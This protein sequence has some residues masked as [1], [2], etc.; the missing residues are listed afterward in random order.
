MQIDDSGG[1]PAPQ[2]VLPKPTQV[3]T[4]FL[5]RRRA[6]CSA[7]VCHYDVCP[8]LTLILFF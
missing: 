4:P 6:S 8:K 5:R 1:A 3:N 7:V 2:V